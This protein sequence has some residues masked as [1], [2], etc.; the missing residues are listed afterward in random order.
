MWVRRDD[1]AGAALVLLLER[2][3]SSAYPAAMSSD[4]SA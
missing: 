1:H 2:V 3:P 4:A